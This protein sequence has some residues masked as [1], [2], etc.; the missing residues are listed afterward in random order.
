M[1]RAD[2]G[3]WPRC[4]RALAMPSMLSAMRVGAGQALDCQGPKLTCA[5]RAVIRFPVIALRGAALAL[6]A[7]MGLR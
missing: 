2:C 3:L 4:F 5:I 7:K 6:F 1:G